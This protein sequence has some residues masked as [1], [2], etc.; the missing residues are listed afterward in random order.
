MEGND[1]L[2]AREYMFGTAERFE[3]ICCAGCGCVQIAEVP[4]DLSKYYPDAYYSFKRTG[5]TNRIQ[6]FLQRQRAAYVMDNRGWIGRLMAAR[7][8][9]PVTLEYLRK[10]G[11]TWKDR[12]L[13]IGCG[14]GERLLAMR[15]YGFTNLTGLDPYIQRSIHYENGV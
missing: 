15:A 3:Y 7:Y 11:V 9:S 5:P 10:A 13:E 14:S 12:I 8:G 2:V 1:T 6:S 4:A